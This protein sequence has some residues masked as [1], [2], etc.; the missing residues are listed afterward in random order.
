MEVS[1]TVF[2]AEGKSW[3]KARDMKESGM[4]EQ[5]RKFWHDRGIYIFPLQR[6]YIFTDK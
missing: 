5:L 6:R 3:T 4:P 2:Q 1:E